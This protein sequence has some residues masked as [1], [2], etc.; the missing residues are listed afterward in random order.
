MALSVNRRSASL[1]GPSTAAKGKYSRRDILDSLEL[2][3]LMLLPFIMIAVFSYLPM[4][5]IVI[6]FQDYSPANGLL[7]SSTQWV[8]MKHFARFINGI[9]FGRLLGNTLRLSLMEFLIGFWIPI[10]LALLLNELKAMRFKKVV[11]TASY[12]PYFI[13]SVVV[14]GMVLSFIRPGGIIDAAAKIMGGSSRDISMDPAA[15]PWVYV[16]TMV[17][18]SFGFAS[19][20]YMSTLSSVDTELYE[21]ARIDGATRWQQMIHISLPSIM[22]VISIQMILSIGSL[23]KSNSDMILLLYNQ[24]VLSTADTFATYVYRSGLQGNNFSFGTAVGLFSNIVNI[25]LMIIANTVSRKANDF[26]LW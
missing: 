22:P 11:Q 24:S 13:S 20:L 12:M 3:S 14:A 25:L 2:Y 10:A 21:A 15:F 23:M 4:L 5:G 16:L 19:I 26:S 18:K 8:G 1:A 17:W 7:T 9:Y 6:A